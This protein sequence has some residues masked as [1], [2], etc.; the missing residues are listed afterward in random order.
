MLETLAAQIRRYHGWLPLLLDL[1]NPHMR[2]RHWAVVF[3]HVG[4]AY[5]RGAMFTLNQLIDWRVFDFPQVR[6]EGN[7]RGGCQAFCLV[8]IVVY[9]VTTPSPPLLLP[10]GRQ[11]VSDVARVSVGESEIDALIEGLTAK[12]KAMTLPVTA[13]EV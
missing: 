4:Q 1:A 13:T 3:S 12:W 9:F 5:E 10:L 2:A 11:V 7:E 8:F 6:G